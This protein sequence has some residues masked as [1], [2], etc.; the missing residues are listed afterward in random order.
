M[1]FLFSFYRMS[2]TIKPKFKCKTRLDDEKRSILQMNCSTV[3]MKYNGRQKKEKTI[4][5][6]RRLLSACQTLDG[7]LLSLVSII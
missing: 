6:C 2:K 4:Y 7:G 5:Y 1:T 3:G